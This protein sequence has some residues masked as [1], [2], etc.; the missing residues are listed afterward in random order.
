MPLPTPGNTELEHVRSNSSQIKAPNFDAV[1]HVR[2][3]VI[4]GNR[5]GNKENSVD[6]VKVEL[7]DEEICAVI[8]AKL[9]PGQT[10]ALAEA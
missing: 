7:S 2:K 6:I 1:K 5:V 4:V 9:R 8:I 10:L 3:A